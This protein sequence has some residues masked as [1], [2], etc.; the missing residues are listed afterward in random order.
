MQPHTVFNFA[1]TT[2]QRANIAFGLILCLLL[3]IKKDKFPETGV[4]ALIILF[5]FIGVLS[6]YI[7]YGN[8]FFTDK[9]LWSFLVYALN[10]VGFLFLFTRF[11]YTRKDFLQ[12]I[13][14][15]VF[16]TAMTSSLAIHDMLFP[17]R[18]LY[19]VEDGRASG[20]FSDAN[21]M[22]AM[23]VGILPLAYYFFL[24][25]RNKYFK[26]MFIVVITIIMLGIFASVSRGGLLGLLFVGFIILKRNMKKSSTIVVIAIG[27]ILFAGFASKLYKERTT[28]K[29]T[30][31]GRTVVDE[32][33]YSRVEHII[34]AL[35]L[36]IKNPILGV[37]IHC[38]QLAQRDQ[39]NYSPGRLGWIHNTYFSVLAEYG[40][41]GFI[42][43]MW[44]FVLAFRSLSRLSKNPDDFYREL[45]FY[46]RTG[47]LGY[48]LC[49]LAL[50]IE[51]A[52]MFLAMAALPVILNKIADIEKK[53]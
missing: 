26:Q 21:I 13:N 29:K 6:G 15:I 36:F 8:F 17:N 2:T 52:I 46:L 37:G 53:T 25:G 24:H 31:S 18:A 7:E 39:L 11:I 32:S 5:V 38:T 33:A 35:N 43:Y 9:S 12:T 10:R 3:L 44:I 14:V 30:L 45:A 28:V 40:L 47:L 20:V 16:F 50:S 34:I 1:Q 19:I 4:N 23:L 42:I 41:I 48:M 51:F 49:A 27:I 22:S